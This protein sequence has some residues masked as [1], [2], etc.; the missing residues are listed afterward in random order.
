[1]F[2]LSGYTNLGGRVQNVPVPLSTITTTCEKEVTVAKC[3]EECDKLAGCT[4]FTK[5]R[6]SCMLYDRCLSGS[7][8]EKIEMDPEKKCTYFKPCEG[9][10]YPKSFG[11]FLTK[12]AHF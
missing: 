12:S 2:L 10:S 11:N 3:M 8:S 6:C 5:D 9:M 4:S 7:L 1:M